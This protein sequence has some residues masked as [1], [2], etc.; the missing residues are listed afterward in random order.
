M[1]D[2][3]RTLQDVRRLIT[4]LGGPECSEEDLRW[5]TD[6]PSGRQLLEWLASQG[7]QDRERVDVAR[8]A[9][10][11]VA[12]DVLY[13]T[14]VS[15]IALY[16]DEVDASARLR[17]KVGHPRSSA[18]ID[19]HKPSALYAL[20]STLR[21]HADTL[22]QEADAL[23]KRSARQKRRAV[24]TKSAVKDAK[25]VASVAKKQ[26]DSVDETLQQQQER[27]GDLSLKAILLVQMDGTMVKCAQEARSSLTDAKEQG[28]T[29]AI[30][31][32]DIASLDRARLAVAGAVGRLYKTLDERYSALPSATEL[33]EDAAGVQARF[34]HAPTSH[35]QVADLAAA[36][37]LEELERL[38][39]RLEKESSNN[40]QDLEKILLSYA[41]VD[42][43]TGGAQ[44]RNVLPD[45]TAELERAGRLDRL[46]LLKAQSQGL[47]IAIHD[48]GESLLPR[49]E[50][51]HDLLNARS[52]TTAETEAIVSALIEELEDVNDTVESTK[53][54]QSSVGGPPDEDPGVLLE[55]SV[56]E[57]LKRLL[58][59]ESSG[60]P[61]VLLNRSDVDAELDALKQRLKA[62]HLAERKWAANLSGRL[63]DLSSSRAALL[64]VAY[65]NAPVNTSVPFAPPAAERQVK[66]EARM[67]AKELTE[68]AARL[69]KQSELGSREQRELA[70]FIKKWTAK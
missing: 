55:V 9:G 60:R 10:G 50:Q 5:A 41:S 52:A 8:R 59:A 32:S 58:R 22:E 68:A 39:D 38:S 3:R 51:I 29:I 27:L 21:A 65:E 19:A 14:V 13:Q 49:L 53:H 62:S 42:N 33:A 46:L 35:S 20:P 54:P 40:S 47:E 7:L 66:N 28:K 36:S 61:T 4:H 63:A 67:K 15:P 43:T 44:P 11:E 24:L 23:E 37:Y 57:L 25:Q 30:L 12:D 2:T 48:I 56:T 26:I 70:A 31:K 1:A 69:Q 45:V 16:K 6:I 17:D 18:T 34:A 64:S